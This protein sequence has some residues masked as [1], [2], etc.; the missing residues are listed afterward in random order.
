M[1]QLIVFLLLG[2]IFV[3]V[4]CLFLGR[5]G[6]RLE[7]GAQAVVSARQALNSLQGALL[8][9][10]LIHRVFA[11]EDLDFVSSAAPPGIR[12]LFIR[13]R[14]AIALRWIRDVRKQVLS[15]KDF[16][17][18]HSRFCA[19]LDLGTEIELALRF[20]SLLLVCRLLEI[21]LYVRGPFAAPKMV[22]RVIDVAGNIC[23]VSERS[24]AFL[25]RTVPAGSVD[26]L[27]GTPTGGAR[28]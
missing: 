19:Q 4:L 21:I 14:K 18:G 26:L 7:G 25:S 24:L 8:P 13:E 6:T 1:M 23:L 22:A 5:Q 28:A 9:P 20:A 3:G 12:K 2:A 16:H 11:R 10:E 27:G 15:L 17:S